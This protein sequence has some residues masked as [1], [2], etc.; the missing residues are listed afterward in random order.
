[1]SDRVT[2][3]FKLSPDEAER[4]EETIPEKYDNRS[5]Y[6]RT[7]AFEYPDLVADL[8]EKEAKLA[9]MRNRLQAT[10]QRIDVTNE[11]VARSEETMETNE[12]LRKRLEASMWKRT[13]WAVLGG[14]PSTEEEA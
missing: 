10:N 3:T 7:A 9:E 2:I 4:L 6:L 12:W 5:E 8:A 14:G 13:K 1:M 11:L